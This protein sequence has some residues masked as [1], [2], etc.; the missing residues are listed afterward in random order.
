MINE[1]EKTVSEVND[2]TKDALQAY[3]E[4]KDLET[5]LKQAVQEVYEIAVGEA[6]KYEKTFHHL[7]FKFELRNGA[8][9]YSFKHIPEWN[10]LNEQVKDFEAT[11]KAALK[12]QGKIQM[13]SNEGE[14]IALP[15]V[16]VSKDSLIVRP[17]KQLTTQQIME[18]INQV[19]SMSASHWYVLS[20]GVLLG[21]IIPFIYLGGV[22]K[23]N[24]KLKQK[25]GY[26]GYK[27]K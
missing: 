23:E 13:A 11:S 16:T 5:I 14:D 2:G 9:R 18:L 3:G 15:I 10:N 20:M 6:S 4:L 24:K 22:I 27:N 7:G 12:M 21:A 26:N 19:L 1:I 8:T 17:A 25:L